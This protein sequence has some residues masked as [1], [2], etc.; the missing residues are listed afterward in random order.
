M[1]PCF[2]AI[3]KYDWKAH[4]DQKFTELIPFFD[5][6]TTRTDFANLSARLF[7]GKI[8]ADHDSLLGEG[9]EYAL[10]RFTSIVDNRLKAIGSMVTKELLIGGEHAILLPR[11]KSGISVYVKKGSGLYIGDK[12]PYPNYS[13]DGATIKREE[14]VVLKSPVPVWFSEVDVELVQ[15]KGESFFHLAVEGIVAVSNR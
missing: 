15:P 9:E 12:G 3:E 10:A 13:A 5:Q 1:H 11:A 14:S 8:I 6:K 7:Y 2:T 4:V